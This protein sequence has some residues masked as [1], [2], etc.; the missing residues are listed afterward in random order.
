MSDDSPFSAQNNPVAAEPD[1]DYPQ[2][3]QERMIMP[4]PI[5][6][7]GLGMIIRSCPACG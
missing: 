2:A 4:V 3:G 1:H 6:A 7:I 5:L